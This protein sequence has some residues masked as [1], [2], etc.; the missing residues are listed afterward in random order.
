MDLKTIESQV[1]DAAK[2][3][4]AEIEKDAKSVFATVTSAMSSFLGLANPKWRQFV[5]D[6][7][8]WTWAKRT[9]F[10]LVA[11]LF[12]WA[13][14]HYGVRV[15]NLIGGNYSAAR[16]YAHGDVVTKDDVVKAAAEQKADIAS[17]QRD[18]D[19]LTS[20]LHQIRIELNAIEAKLAGSASAK[21]D[22]GS[23]P[24]KKKRR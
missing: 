22:T 18:I 16:A 1:E 24:A 4:G 19:G 2:D 15:S 20:D 13:G 14:V 8:V 21:I 11:A 10:L 17:L 3:I 7:K 6:W 9:A 12:I 23:I 5:A